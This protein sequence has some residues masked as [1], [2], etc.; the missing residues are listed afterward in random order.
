M[1]RTYLDWIVELP[2]Q[3]NTADNLDLEHVNEVLEKNHYGLGKVKDRILEYIA[4][5]KLKPDE[6]R[7]P[8]LCFCWCTR[9][10]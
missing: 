9:H 1:I 4:V 5:Q 3:E 6:A 2:W 10:R 7:Q 8:I